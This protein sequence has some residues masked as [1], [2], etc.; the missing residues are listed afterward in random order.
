[1]RSGIISILFIFLSLFLL[2]FVPL[3]NAQNS[4]KVAVLYF[5][6]RSNFD[7]SSGCGCISLGPL[8]SLFGFGQKREKW[9]L[10]EGFRDLLNENL[11]K[12]GYNVIESSYVDEVL[13][14]SDRSNMA[15]IANKL[16]A[17]IIF[18]GDITK[19][20]QHRTRVSTHGPTTASTGGDYGMKMNL[21][22]DI[23]GFY[24][25][26]SVNTKILIY[27]NTGSEIENGEINSK[28]DLKDFFMGIGPLR[29]EYDGGDS[30]KDNK[31]E[32]KELIVDYQKLDKM[33]FGTEEFK[34][35]TLFGLA[36]MDVMSQITKKVGEHIDPMSITG[37][38]GKIIYVS[39]GKHLKENEVYI[40]IG[41][42]DGLVIGN[43]LAIFEEDADLKQKRIGLLKVNKIEAEHLSI[44]EIIEKIS[45]IKKGNIIRPE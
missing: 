22:N 37:V 13:R 15:D 43:K 19:F 26:S 39:D 32:K 1:L 45:E 36:T 18:V 12:S 27:D 31:K 35:N 41:A 21:K 38:E 10:S 20:E 7:R 6:D 29:K 24:Y 33:K 34:E 4:G 30:I 17:E 42:G 28:K 40:D 23:G 25:S 9:N 5:I 14:T 11:K 44:A 2:S 16:G 8:N 3:A